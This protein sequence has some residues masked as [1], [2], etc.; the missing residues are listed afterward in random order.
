M[1]SL[2]LLPH[3]HWD[4]DPGLGAENTRQHLECG[5][6]APLW[7]GYQYSPHQLSGSDGMRSPQSRAPVNR[8]TLPPSRDWR[9]FGSTALERTPLAQRMIP[10]PHIRRARPV[11]A[12][13]RWLRPRKR[14]EET[15]HATV[16][17]IFNDLR[18]RFMGSPLFHLDL[19]TGQEP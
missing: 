4:L 17:L 2:H 3:A 13:S 11:F 10:K 19:L 18:T 8:R 9:V 7:I 12:A 15:V 1:G 6:L 5:A 16:L 14:C